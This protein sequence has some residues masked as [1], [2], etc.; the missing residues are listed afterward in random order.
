MP[1]VQY[2]PSAVYAPVVQTHHTSGGVRFILPAPLQAQLGRA[3]PGSNAP[4]AG[5]GMPAGK[6]VQAKVTR[7]QHRLGQAKPIPGFNAP[8]A[9]FDTP[10]GKGVHG[11]V[12]HTNYQRHD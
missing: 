1:L 8:R 3:I 9:G 10:A 2:A 4:W 5:F 11:Q 7:T 6:G 12:T